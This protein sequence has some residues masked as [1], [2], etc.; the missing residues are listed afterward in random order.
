MSKFATASVLSPQLTEH[1]SGHFL[2]EW[3][4]GRGAVSGL[5]KA[6]AAIVA[7]MSRFRHQKCTEIPT[8]HCGGHVDEDEA[9]RSEKD[10]S[11]GSVGYLSKG[12]DCFLH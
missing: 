11:D 2:V 1:R 9:Q 3:A 10:V 6:C 12:H 7:S 8:C 4:N 5:S